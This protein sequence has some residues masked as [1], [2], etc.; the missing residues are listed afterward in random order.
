MSVHIGT[1]S[2]LPQNYAILSRF[3]TSSALDEDIEQSDLQGTE[4]NH[5]DATDRVD[6]NSSSN[7]RTSF[8]SPYI[9]PAQPVMHILPETQ[10]MYPHSNASEN[11]PLLAPLMPRIEESVDKSGGDEDTSR[12]K[13]FWEEFRILAKY[14]LPVYITQVFEYSLIMA[15][16]ISIGHI[17]TNALAAATLGSMTANVSG[18]SIVL[19]FATTLDTLL[20]G[21]WTSDNPQLVGLWTQRM[22]VVTAVSL[23]PILAIWFNSEAIL[24]LLRQEPEVAHLAGIYM[25][26]AS[27][28]LPAYAFNNI[29]R[30]YFQSQGLFAV[31][32]RI[33]LVIAPINAVLNYILVWGPEPVRLGFIGAPIA[34]A[35]SFNLVSIASVA[36]GVFFVQKT[37]WHPISKRS[38]TSLGLLVQLGLGGVGQ[39]ASEWWSWELVGLAASQ[40]GPV[41]LATQSVVLNSASCTFQAPFAL[42]V[43]ASVRIGNLLGEKNAKR[44]GVSAN[45]AILVSIAIAGVW[46]TLFLTFRKSWGHLFNDDPE[47][48]SLV[49]TIL[50]LVALFQVFDGT[51]AVS[52]GIFRARGKQF[53]GA[54]LNLSAYYVLGIPFGIWLAFKKDMQLAGLWIGLTLALI[55]SSAWGIYLCLKTDWKREVSKVMDRLASD[56]KGIEH[57]AEH[58]GN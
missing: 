52:A 31:P 5:Y 48:V 56:R 1:P 11:T 34:T 22:V 51:S 24:L 10:N 36:Y 42:S 8:P 16:V 21:A 39:T 40:L 29:I 41:A 23:I 27:I 43:A 58:R 28:G 30:R 2:S 55:Y 37:A 18:Y 14:T 44:A 6:S 49:S 19:G 26:W 53:T 57:D 9:R 50:P 7:R 46:S 15:S 33:I 17:S 4:E 25:K 13:M 32:T 54:L 12:I 20:P 35:I 45:A 47:V 3:A 38:F